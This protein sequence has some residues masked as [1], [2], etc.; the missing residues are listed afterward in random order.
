[1]FLKFNQ[2][3]TGF[4]S[5]VQSEDDK[6]KYIEDQQRSERIALDKASI[7]KNSGQRS[8]AN[9]KLNS[10]WSKWAQ[11]QNKSQTTIVELVK[12]FYELLT[13]AGTE[14]TNLIFPNNEVVWI[15]WKYSENNL[16]TGKMSTWLLLLTLQNK[17][18]L[19]CT[20]I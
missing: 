12:V 2:E 20:I 4:P 8:L 13:N 7:S 11:N 19:N 10:I 5:W 15:P 16:T 1:M 18:E 9:L 6:D 17:L 3:S 14:V